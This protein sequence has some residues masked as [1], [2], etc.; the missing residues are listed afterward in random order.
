MFDKIY[1]KDTHLRPHLEAPLLKER[2]QFVSRIANRGYCIR[3]QQMVAAYL[4]YAVQYLDLEDEDLTPVSLTA[5]WEMGQSYRTKRLTSKRRRNYSPDVKTKYQDQLYYT[6]IWLKEIGRLDNLY[7]ETDNILNQLMVKD[8]YRVKFLSAPLLTERLSYLQH[9]MDTGCCLRT[10]IRAAAEMQITI[11]EMLELAN[12]RMITIPEIDTAFAKWN[13]SSKGNHRVNSV[14]GR[15]QF[16]NVAFNWLRHA[17]MLMEAVKIVHEESWIDR[18]CQWLR[19]EKGL[20]ETTIS[21]RKIELTHLTGYLHSIGRDIAKLSP[22][23]IDDYLVQRGKDGCNRRTLASIVTCLRDFTH[24]AFLSQWISRDLSYCIHGPRLFP[25]EDLPYAPDWD[26]VKKLVCYY[27]REDAVSIRN[28]A[29]ML[30]LTVYGLRT[31]EV[32]DMKIGDIDWANDIILI[33]HKKRGRSMQYPLFPEVGNALVRYLKDVRRN[34]R[35]DRHLFLTMMAPYRGISR[36]GI[37]MIVANAYKG[38]GETAK[39]IGGHSLRH[40]CASKLV[41]SGHP[42]KTVSDVLGHRSL[43]STRVYAKLD[44]SSLS[45]VSE[46]NWEGLI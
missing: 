29:I 27:N 22:A 25:H 1:L 30:L 23:V 18:Y 34:D 43:D 36:G 14:K 15:K 33:N 4:L 39:H 11:I 46:M 8:F 35:N 42:L 12:P 3:Y 20:S 6:V 40:A 24:Y 2:E 16:Y 9:L 17:G 26:T 32:V 21:D 5:I 7:N 13:S 10:T 44:L 37:Y 31:S 45:I 19:E 28:Q 41:N 38:I